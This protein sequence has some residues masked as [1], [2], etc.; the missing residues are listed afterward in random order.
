MNAA[1]QYGQMNEK[2]A[3]HSYCEKTGEKVMECGLF[4]HLDCGYL[5]ASP[6]GLTDSGGIIKVKCPKAAE[7][8]TI[9]ESIKTIKGFCLDKL[10]VTG[11]EWCDF[12]V[13]T[14][15]DIYVERIFPDYDFWRQTLLP[16]LTFF[17]EKVLLPEI[18]DPRKCTSMDIRE[19]D[20]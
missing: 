14:D 7:H 4:V 9:Q 5:A 15:N 16:K 17:F 18:V 13:W 1:V 8:L 6:D 3:I 12:I 10:H 2:N 11:K 19:P 20:N